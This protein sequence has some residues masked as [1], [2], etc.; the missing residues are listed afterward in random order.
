MVYSNAQENRQ[1]ISVDLVKLPW[2]IGLPWGHSG[3]ESAC[4]AGDAG[5]IP[6]SERSPEGGLDNP[7]QCF[8]LG[9]PMDRGAWQATVHGVAKE[10]D[11]T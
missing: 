3:E 9:N 2:C 8:C 7:L 1:L 10:S 5:L 6:G 11:T 4:N